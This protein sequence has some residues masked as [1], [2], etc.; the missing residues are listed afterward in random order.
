[1]IAIGSP[2]RL[3][4]TVTTGIVSALNRP[5]PIFSG[6]VVPDAIQTSAAINQGNSGG[7]LIGP[8]GKV[9]G[10][11]TLGLKEGSGLAFAIPAERALRL[12]VNIE[13]R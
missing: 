4:E 9:I 13:P 1:V 3:T 10:V 8:D 12:Y 2:H 5:V 7:P 6:K 11:N